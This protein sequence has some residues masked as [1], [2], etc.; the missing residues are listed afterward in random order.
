MIKIKA[1]VK[2]HSQKLVTAIL[3]CSVLYGSGRLYFSLTDGF[4]VSNIVCEL[5]ADPARELRAW[6]EQEMQEWQK[7]SAQSWHYLG[8]GCQS[9]VF[10]SEDGKY[11]LKFFKYQRFRPQFWL[12]P[13]SFLPP[14][15]N[16]IDKKMVKKYEKLA[17]FM[18]AW[19]VAFEELKDESGLVLVHLN[20]S[21]H[22]QQDFVLYDK[23]GLKHKVPADQVEFLVQ[24]KADGLISWI[25]QHMK[26]QQQEIV[27]LLLDDLVTTLV[28]EY[29]RGLSDD[30]PALMQNTGVYKNRPFHIDVGQF[31]KES[32]Y[33][34]PA[35]WHQALFNKTYNFRI[36]LLRH[37]PQLGEHLTH[38]LESEIGEDWSSMKPFF[39]RIH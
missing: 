25:D 18:Q 3:L 12:E 22:L 10:E 2:R 26:M 30:D 11:V 13:F 17:F 20:K 1:C 39:G 36:W 38:R 16:Y 32:R 27:K 6:S 31:T 29:S 8:K 21:N 19:K 4:M 14:V 34:D 15:K 7:V 33:Q 37:Y 23:L 28:S 9:Y 24:K 35:T 5:P